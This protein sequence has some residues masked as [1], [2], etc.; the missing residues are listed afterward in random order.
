MS[1]PWHAYFAGMGSPSANAD[2][3]NDS[4][5]SDGLGLVIGLAS[6][7]GE[8]AAGVGVE[9]CA[10]VASGLTI[11]VGD[12][13]DDPV[14]HPVMSNA[15]ATAMAGH[16][17]RMPSAS[18]SDMRDRGCARPPSVANEGRIREGRLREPFR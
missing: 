5:A 4:R 18:L 6:G 7:D 1:A 13:A 9:G 3:V 15:I 2:D 8:P 14:L 17:L 11:A 10:A 12:I 16:G